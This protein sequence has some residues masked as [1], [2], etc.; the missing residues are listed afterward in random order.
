[1]SIDHSGLLDRRLQE[2]ILILDGAMGTMIQKYNLDE[3]G[4]RGNRFA[5]WEA[6]VKGNNDLLTLSQPEIISEIHSAYLEAGADIIETNTFN[7]NR[8]SLADYKMASLAKEINFKAA[9]IAKEAVLSKT[10]SNPDRPR[11][12]A[13]VLGPTNRTASLSPDVNDPGFRNVDFNQLV[14]TYQEAA[15]GLIEGGS[16]VLLIETIFDTLNAKAA[17]YACFMAFESLGVRLP[18]MVSGTITDQS[19]RTLSGQTPTA[20]WASLSHGELMSI[21]LNCALGADALRPHI[22]ELAAV[23]DTAI[24]AHPNAGLPNEFG[25]YD[26]TPA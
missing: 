11:F 24:S 7:A 9:A 23:A 6:E 13:G 5:D 22:Q 20:F 4:Y 15:E 10:T 18:L 2:S 17:L 19:G 14:E 3:A 26:E 21:G 16:D 8:I 25:E 12:V 1:M